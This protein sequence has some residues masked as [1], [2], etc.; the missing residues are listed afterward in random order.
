M[1]GHVIPHYLW[2]L[3]DETCGDLAPFPRSVEFHWSLSA[4]DLSKGER[5]G[6]K[7]CC[8]CRRK[9]SLSLFFLL[10]SRGT[11]GKE[12]TRRALWIVGNQNVRMVMTFWRL[13][14]FLQIFFYWWKHLISIIWGRDGEGGGQFWWRF[15]D[16]FG[17]SEALLSRLV[18]AQT[19]KSWLDVINSTVWALILRTVCH[20]KAVNPGLKRRSLIQNP[21]CWLMPIFPTRK[22]GLLRRPASD[23]TSK[24][25]FFLYQ[26]IKLFQP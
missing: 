13:C 25:L 18:L 10:T 2:G 22:P 6:E 14:N 12:I 20:L 16:C 8:E 1:I 3:I 4:R 23:S 15:L 17:G 26:T 9:M 7:C 19:I 5:C 24:I 11:N 21:T